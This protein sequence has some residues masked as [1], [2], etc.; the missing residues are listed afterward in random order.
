M[1]TRQRPTTSQICRLLALPLLLAVLALLAVLFSQQAPPAAAQSAVPRRVVEEG[2]SY[3]VRMTIQPQTTKITVT[4]ILKGD[5]RL[6]E[7]YDVRPR[8]GYSGDYETPGW[9]VLPMA[10]GRTPVRVWTIP[11]SQ[12]RTVVTFTIDVVDD[13]VSEGDEVINVSIAMGGLPLPAVYTAA[14]DRSLRAELDLLIPANDGGA[15]AA[16]TAGALGALPKPQDQGQPEQGPPQQQQAAPNQLEPYSIH[17]F[18]G[19]GTLTVLWEVS[20]RDGFANDEIRHALRWSQFPG[21]WANP[22]DPRAGGREDGLSVPGGVAS[23]TITGLQNGVATGVF[24]RSF[25]GGSYSERSEH[26]SRWV[27]VKGLQTTPRGGQQQQQ[28]QQQAPQPQQ[29]QQA[30]QPQQPQQQ[31]PQPQPQQ[32]QPQ[33]T[34]Q[35]QPQQQQPQPT[36]QPQQ[37]Q[38]QPT[39]QPQQ[40]QQQTPQPQASGQREPYN[41]QVIPGDG[42]LTVTWEVSPRDGFANGEIRHAL[43]W[44]QASGVWANPL[45]PRAGGREDGLSVAGGVASYTITGLQNGVATGVFVRSFTGGSYSERS[46]YSSR[47][48]RTKGD[49]TTP[50]A[51]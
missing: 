30:P 25:T 3:T 50:R 37:Q 23:Y 7:D 38:P 11:A 35:P 16:G 47:W 17:V 34:P 18:P 43:R 21:V 39:P 49:H 15:G 33:P 9:Y 24:V 36:P 32:Q 1:F 12:T 20:P 42:T 2:D 13:D 40:Q 26:S 48:V 28:Q 4:A 31:A 45:D 10:S 46:E 6:D 27:R 14:Y 29:Q 44:S 19:D 22:A 8:A 5:A 51:E 41:I